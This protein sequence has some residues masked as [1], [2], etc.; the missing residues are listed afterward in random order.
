MKSG[1]HFPALGPNRLIRKTADYQTNLV[2]F[3]DTSVLNTDLTR[4]PLRSRSTSLVGS[5]AIHIA[6]LLVYPFPHVVLDPLQMPP[7]GHT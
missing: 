4:S 2:P 3:S 6:V 1:R 5:V 7:R